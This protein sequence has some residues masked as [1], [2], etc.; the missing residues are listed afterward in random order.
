[1][2]ALFS[3]DGWT[4][5]LDSHHGKAKATLNLNNGVV[6]LETSSTLPGYVATGALITFKFK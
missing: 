3:S 5:S 6:E 4:I 1:M 2:S